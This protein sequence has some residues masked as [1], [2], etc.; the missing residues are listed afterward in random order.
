MKKLLIILLTVMLFS[1]TKENE[2]KICL[3]NNLCDVTIITEVSDST[4]FV[5]YSLKIYEDDLST[6]LYEDS[7]YTT[8]TKT[9]YFYGVPVGVL[10]LNITKDIKSS[11][12]ILKSDTSILLGVCE[13]KIINLYDK[14]VLDTTIIVDTIDYEQLKLD[15]IVESLGD[16]WFIDSILI[17]I[18]HD[19]DSITYDNG[20]FD[21]EDIW[22]M[23][24]VITYYYN[25][26]FW[27]N[28][29]WSYA[30]GRYHRFE[31]EEVK[32]FK[33]ERGN[34]Y[35][36]KPAFIFEE[37]DQLMVY[38]AEAVD[39]TIPDKYIKLKLSDYVNIY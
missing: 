20:Y 10:N 27:Y 35:Y 11:D 9:D 29:N 23:D 32:Y 4:E 33:Y 26:W 14:I 24:F 13:E 38:P 17:Q 5:A 19:A 30:I 8:D 12:M 37:P 25:D 31:Y 22:I 7:V 21:V 34:I 18:T 2:T 39:A 28:G 15:S 6:L 3:D 36:L 1:C 16:D